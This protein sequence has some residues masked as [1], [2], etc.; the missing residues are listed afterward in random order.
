M[1]ARGHMTAMIS[2]RQ[3]RRFIDNP[4]VE[5]TMFVVG[6]LLLIAALIVGP[7][8]G[9]GGVFF[10]VPGLILVLKTSMWAR[11]RYVRFKRWQPKVL[12]RRIVPGRW[13]DLALRRQSAL[14]RERLRKEREA[15]AKAEQAGPGD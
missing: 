13:T 5:W 9:P 11:R 7:L 10:A 4:V 12:G 15:V 3:W 14:R 2:R 1:R 8:P 6:V